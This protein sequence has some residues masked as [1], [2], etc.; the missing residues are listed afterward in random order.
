MS[1]KHLTPEG[2]Q[3]FNNIR[4]SINGGKLFSDILA[5]FPCTVQLPRPSIE[6]KG[7]PDPF[8]LTGF[9][10]GDGC[11]RIKTRKSP[12]NKSGLSINLGFIITQH[13]RDLA[14]IQ[15]LVSYFNCGGHSI[16][17]DSLSCEFHVYRTAHIL[18]LIIPFFQ[19]Y[20]LQGAKSLDFSYFS[21]AAEI[22]RVKG[23][24]DW[25]RIR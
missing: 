20:P 16:A 21:K 22:L 11:F 3:E 24:S 23:S 12:A 6:F 9:T 8:W 5:D 17:T 4:A 19:R 1:K 13:I 14:L 15:G 25:R 2:L 10:D 18:D 7:M